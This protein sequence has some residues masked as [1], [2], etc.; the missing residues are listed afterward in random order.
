MAKGLVNI[1]WY[2]Q[3][4]TAIKITVAMVIAAG[5]TLWGVFRYMDNTEDHNKDTDECITM[6][7]DDQKEILY[8]IDYLT[9]QL[10]S[11]NREVTGIKENMYSQGEE[12]VTLRKSYI[13]YLKKNVE[14]TEQFM[15]YVDGLLDEKKNEN[16]NLRMR[17]ID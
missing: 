5:A 7:L 15:E 12:L 4:A 16:V 2:N 6:I 3:Y 13:L 17:G 10:D 8:G 14:K 11:I 9:K 1:S